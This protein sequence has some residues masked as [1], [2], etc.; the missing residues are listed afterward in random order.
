VRWESAPI[1]N[2]TQF[3]FLKNYPFL[4]PIPGN[5]ILFLPCLVRNAPNRMRNR[6]GNHRTAILTR[7]DAQYSY[8]T[9]IR[10][11]IRFAANRTLIRTGNRLRVD[12]PFDMIPRLAEHELLFSDCHCIVDNC[13]AAARVGV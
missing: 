10:T 5:V 9:E 2:W 7:L 1:F 8:R 6:T 4:L 13:A 11:A 12:G 3:N